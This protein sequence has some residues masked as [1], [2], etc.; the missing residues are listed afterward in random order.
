[1]PVPEDLQC[2]KVIALLGGLRGSLRISS[3]S[4][5]AHLSTSPQTA[6]RRLQA[7][8]RDELLMPTM[9]PDGQAVTVSRAGESVLKEE[10]V[11]Y[12]RLFEESNG[13]FRLAGAVVT[14]LGEGRYYMGL[15]EYQRQFHA[16]LG[17]SPYPGTL[18]IRLTPSSLPVRKRIDT[19]PWVM[20]K[21]FVA[22][23][24]TFGDVKCLSCRIEEIPC[25]IVV[26][27]RTHYPEDVLEIV[28]PVGI[29]DT[30]G[31]TDG[32]EVRVEVAA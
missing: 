18:N 12:R 25:G 22:D 16:Y 4:L 1:M 10:Y 17:F 2:L 28:A 7:L 20:V 9:G 21:G 15:T 32:D 8:E 31:V 27:G 30:L 5:A 26:P 3:Q 13:G 14:G 29:R 23:Q 19:L 11:E 6:S 24:R